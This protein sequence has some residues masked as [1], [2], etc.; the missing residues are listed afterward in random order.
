MLTA[1]DEEWKSLIEVMMSLWN[2]WTWILKLYWLR[3]CIH[4]D[5]MQLMPMKSLK[6]DTPNYYY[7]MV[8][9]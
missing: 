6:A 2:N 8:M 1:M 4:S 3:S 7:G 9:M 5:K